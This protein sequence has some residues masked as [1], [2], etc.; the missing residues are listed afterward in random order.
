YDGD[1]T[2]EPDFDPM[3]CNGHG[4]HVAGIAG[5]SGVNGD[6]TTFA[7]P[8]GPGTDFA[9][10][11]IGPGV[12]PAVSIYALKVFGCDG[13]TRVTDLAIE[14]A[15]DPNGDGDFSDHLD[16]INMS[17]GSNYGSSDDSSA[18]A[19]NN[20]A[21]AGVSVIASSGN[22]GDVYYISGSPGIASRV[23]NVANI[24][25]SFN[26]V[27]VNT[28]AGIAGL[29][30][31]S[32]AAF[33][34]ALSDPG[35]TQ[36]LIYATP[37]NGCTAIGPEV[38]G[39]VALVDRG[40]CNF[41]VKVKNAQNAGAVAVVVANNV[42][43]PPTTMGGTDA[44]ITIPSVMISLNSATIIK[45][46][47]PAPGVNVTLNLS[48]NGPGDVVS[49]SSS[50]GPRRAESGL[51]P[52]ISAPGSGITSTGAGTGNDTLTIS[53]T[54]MAAPHVAGAIALLR[55]S[56]PSWTVEELKAMV[57]NTA[58]H[59]LYFDT[60]AVPPKYGP[61]RIG[62]GR[63]DVGDAIAGNA[64]AYNDDD[65]GVVSVSFGV[66]EVVGT[67][68]ATK[69]VR[70]VN[71]S[72]SSKTYDIAYVGL[73]DVPGVD[74]SFPDGDSITIGPGGTGTFRIQFDADASIMQHTFDPTI[75][76]LQNG[77]PRHWLSEEGGYVTLTPTSSGPVLRV[78]L[79]AAARPASDMTTAETTINLPDPTGTFTINQT[80]IQVYTGDNV[81]VDEVSLV[82][83]FELQ[84]TSPDDGSST[85]LANNADLKHI[86]IASDVAVSGSAEDS[87][88]TFGIATHAPWSSP[89][90]VEFDIYI[91]TDRDGTDDWVL[92][93]LDLASLVAPGTRNDVYVT[94]LCPL[95]SGGC[96]I[97]AFMND[98]G[99]DFLHSVPMNSNVISMPVFSSDLGLVTG[100]SDFDYYV[101]SFSRDADDFVDVSGLHTYDAANVGLDVSNGFP[102]SPWFTDF[103]GFALD[104]NY[105]VANYTA[106]GSSGLLLLH[107]HNGSGD[108]DQV[109]DLTIGPSNL[110]VNEFDVLPSWDFTQTWEIITNLTSGGGTTYLSP[111][112]N[113]KSKAIG[114]DFAG[115]LTC[116]YTA[117]FSTPANEKYRVWFWFHYIDD[118]NKIE[119][120]IKEGRLNLRQIVNG[121]VVKK[122]NANF[123]L[124]ANQ[125]YTVTISWD[126][127][128]YTASL[129]GG[130]PTLTVVPQGTPAAGTIG[131]GASK[132][133]NFD[134]VQVD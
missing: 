93:N 83:L 120:Q 12:A 15:V 53:G 117:V 95:P 23:I 131:L 24:V 34:G 109:I 88:L 43:G 129:D 107:H 32:P 2:P 5:G 33:G 40:T 78:P 8:Y 13:S 111:T 101:V 89:N 84:E 90:D 119:L 65:D 106:A 46:Q 59:D 134:R 132:D 86:G 62:A 81:P 21:L 122:K 28:P 10:M 75:A 121:V 96:F 54:S 104:V 77:L 114:T 11:R 25:D 14:W 41:T 16:V 133:A 30:A 80:G 79:Y 57:M 4:S 48:N 110:Y 7:G 1:N 22:A 31:A 27:Q 126:G 37:T 45:T 52:D 74:F 100:D 61:G 42:A 118:D 9:S 26:A 35:I 94:V 102:F 115:C 67:A 91:D 125:I 99:A 18:I 20:A 38:S 63:L 103:D 98:L 112:T 66:Q 71:K 64:M 92:F 82:T 123:N 85:G 58:N 76:L 3:D 29:Y 49:S 68:T 87:Y 47:L 70:V 19:A 44:T 56:H 124:V 6:G 72:G 39:K 113:S 130:G 116:T 17:L 50:R 51:K 105:N 128:Q 60:P 108:K 55:Q 97:E 73:A 127:T 69:N 36:D